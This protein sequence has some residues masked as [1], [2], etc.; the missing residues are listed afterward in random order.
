MAN[1]CD[2]KNCPSDKVC[3]PSSGR[4]V[5]K[6]GKV[7]KQVKN[8]SRSR[9]KSKSPKKEELSDRDFLLMQKVLGLKAYIISR[10]KNKVLKGWRNL[11]KVDLVDFII[12]NID[13]ETGEIKSN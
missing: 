8:R 7:G 2:N 5:K 3:N 11:K 1:K 9:S 4:C 13:V 12:R 10:D 6:T